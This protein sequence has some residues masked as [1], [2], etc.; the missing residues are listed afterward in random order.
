MEILVDVSLCNA[1]CSLNTQDKNLIF[2]LQFKTSQEAKDEIK[3][4]YKKL[5]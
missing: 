4:I 3:I 1:L 5:Y 2:Y